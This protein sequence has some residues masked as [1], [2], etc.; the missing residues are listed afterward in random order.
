MFSFCLAFLLQYNTSPPLF[1]SV[2]FINVVPES[3][4]ASS[5][6]RL[7]SGYSSLL[8]GAH[9]RN[10]TVAVVIS[11]QSHSFVTTL[12]HEFTDSTHID[13]LG[14][15]GSRGC[16]KCMHFTE[17]LS[18]TLDPQD[19]PTTCESQCTSKK[20]LDTNFANKITYSGLYT[21]LWHGR[22]A[23][24]TIPCPLSFHLGFYPGFY[25][26]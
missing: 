5:S 21:T 19:L 15:R 12:E 24:N 26:H 8:G 2:G 1:I 25:H 3:P 23:V 9:N 4:T 6:T 11:C 18:E 13:P 20:H 22:S 17:D 10:K 7:R 16:Q 14:M